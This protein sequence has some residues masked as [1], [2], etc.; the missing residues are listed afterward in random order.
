MLVKKQ[1]V[2]G[3]SENLSQAVRE[4]VAAIPWGHI[5]KRN[6][7]NMKRFFNIY[8]YSAIW[9]QAVAELPGMEVHASNW[10]RDVAKLTSTF[11]EQ[12]VQ[13]ILSPVPYILNH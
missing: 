12:L 5:A 9:Q 2:L 1:P 13:E 3:V 4:L 7:R 11:L 8:A 10:R 6:L